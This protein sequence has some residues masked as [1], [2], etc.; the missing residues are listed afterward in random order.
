MSQAPESQ[1][2]FAYGT[3]RPDEPE[4][5][6]HGPKP[7]LSRSRCRAPGRLYLLEE[8]YPILA[9][10]SSSLL[11]EASSDWLRDWKQVLINSRP[12]ETQKP[13]SDSIVGELL[14]VPLAA[15]S[16]SAPDAWEGFEIGGKSAYRRFAIMTFREDG[17]PAP[18]WAYGCERPPAS[19]TLLMGDQWER[20]P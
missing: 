6:L 15:D 17:A 1:F 16:L 2:L 4:Y 13:S 18:A 8:G 14:E 11:L 10:Q 3:L 20:T 7:I 19:A 5:Q 9:I 12:F